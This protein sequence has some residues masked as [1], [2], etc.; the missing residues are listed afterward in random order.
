MEYQGKI[1]SE[2]PFFKVSDMNSDGN[3]FQM[4]AFRNSVSREQADVLGAKIFP[5]GATIF[6]K[7]GGA[8]LTNKR[9]MLIQ[10]SCVDNNI[11]AFVPTVGNA[12][13]WYWVLTL[14][15]FG[16]LSNPGPVPA[17]NASSIKDLPVPC[18]EL[19]EQEAIVKYIKNLCVEL[20]AGIALEQ[21]T[22]GFILEYRDRLIADVVTG[23]IDVRDWLPGPDDEVADED[24]AALGGDEDIEPNGEDEDGEE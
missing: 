15:D 11:M 3:G 13:Y 8:L 22:I 20:D 23:Q 7:V 19:Y 17:L 21:K 1:T 14:L 4:I 18:P 12:E 2:I 16:K 24:L 9:R 6:P 5:K 10:Q